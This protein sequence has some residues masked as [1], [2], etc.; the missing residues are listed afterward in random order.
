MPLTA[1]LMRWSLQFMLNRFRKYV[2]AQ[3]D[4]KSDAATPKADAA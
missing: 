3:P 4:R 1:P 2:E